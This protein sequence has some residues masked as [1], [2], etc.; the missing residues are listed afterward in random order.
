MQ[1]VE[2]VELV[3]RVLPVVVLV[4]TKSSEIV[5]KKRLMQEERKV[6]TKDILT[7]GMLDVIVEITARLVVV[8]CAPFIAALPEKLVKA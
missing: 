7:H 8:V 6:E 2:Q 1:V 4:L 5:P 3:K